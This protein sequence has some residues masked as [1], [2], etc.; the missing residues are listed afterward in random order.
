MGV[1]AAL[2]LSGLSILQAIL[3]FNIIIPD[4]QDKSFNNSISQTLLVLS[5]EC[6]QY[7]HK[8]ITISS[9]Q[10][11]VKIKDLK[12]TKPFCVA[13]RYSTY[14]SHYKTLV[15]HLIGH[16]FYNFCNFTYL[17]SIILIITNS[18]RTLKTV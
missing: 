8:L 16:Y 17:S 1:H 18:Q 14:M 15:I 13:K 5:N 2:L 11:S 12:F 3:F 10:H 4:D 7:H 6:Q 9:T